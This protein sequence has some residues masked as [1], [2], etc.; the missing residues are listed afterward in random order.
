MIKECCWDSLEIGDVASAELRTKSVTAS[1]SDLDSRTTPRVVK[2]SCR[3]TSVGSSMLES[4][5]LTCALAKNTAYAMGRITHRIKLIHLCLQSMILR[6]IVSSNATNEG[7]PLYFRRNRLTSSCDTVRRI[8]R[9][10]TPLYVDW[11]G[12]Q[13]CTIYTLSCR[14]RFSAAYSGDG[15]RDQSPCIER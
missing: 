8:A 12:L 11:R 15:H 4:R 13:H 10:K 14:R 9:R 3:S 1:P 6:T 2:K 7:Y 5:S